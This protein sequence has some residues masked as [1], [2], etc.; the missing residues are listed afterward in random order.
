MPVVRPHRQLAWVLWTP[1]SKFSTNQLGISEPVGEHLG[2][3]TFLKTDIR[4][5]PALAVDKAGKRLGQ[6]GGFYDALTKNL[7]QA[8]WR[9]TYT[10]IFSREFLDEVPAEEHDFTTYAILTEKGIHTFDS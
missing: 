10:V 7:S 9:T 8:A 3:E 6:G 5:I 4:L 1:T 2:P